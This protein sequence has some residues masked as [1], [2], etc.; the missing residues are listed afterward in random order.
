VGPVST[1]QHP[2]VPSCIVPAGNRFQFQEGDITPRAGRG[3]TPCSILKF[4]RRPQSDFPA[5][6][7]SPSAGQDPPGASM[8]NGFRMEAGDMSTVGDAPVRV[9]FFPINLPKGLACGPK[10]GPIGSDDTRDTFFS[11]Q[12]RRFCSSV[13][14]ATSAAPLA[15]EAEMMVK[16]RTAPPS[17][18]PA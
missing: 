4:Q 5:I 7:R 14:Q 9:A 11:G 10:Q 6:T 16:S 15:L 3:S 12:G 1:S 8:N 18:R 17:R 13:A 2:L